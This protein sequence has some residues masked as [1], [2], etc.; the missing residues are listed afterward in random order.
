MKKGIQT[1]CLRVRKMKNN[2][3]TKLKGGKN[4]KKI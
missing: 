1:F 2:S 4:E 3:H